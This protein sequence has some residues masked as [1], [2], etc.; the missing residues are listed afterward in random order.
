MESFQINVSI[1]GLPDQ[2]RVVP[3]EVRSHEDQHK[4]E[5]YN[6]EAY[7]GTVYPDC[8]D[9]GLCWFSSDDIPE[10]TLEKIGEAIERYDR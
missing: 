2:L 6:E 4:Y 1:D 5:I 3:L 8:V 10:D 7:M 9:A